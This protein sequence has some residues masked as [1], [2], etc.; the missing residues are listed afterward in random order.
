MSTF[1]IT[2][3]T[4]KINAFG[5]LGKKGYAA[6][7]L[8]DDIF[9]KVGATIISRFLEPTKTW[10]NP[11]Q[12]YIDKLYERGKFGYEFGVTGDTYYWVNYGTKPH[13]IPADPT[14]SIFIPNV[15]VPKTNPFSLLAGSGTRSS[16]GTYRKTPVIQSITARRF[17]EVIYEEIVNSEFDKTLE[18]DIMDGVIE[19]LGFDSENE[20][21]TFSF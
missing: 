12:P 2:T 14:V 19:F 16:S 17:D 13:E 11:P 1:K 21:T 18:Q 15:N 4:F 20:Q 6:S 10:S 8:L 7:L 5:N 3:D 9:S